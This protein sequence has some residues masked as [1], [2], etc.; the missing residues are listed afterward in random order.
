M[1]CP[2]GST[3]DYAACCEPVI[4]G[5]REAATCEELMRARYSSYVKVEMEFLQESLHPDKREDADADGAREWA[6]SSQ[7][8]GLE[9]VATADGESGDDTGQVEFIASYTFDG[10]EQHYREIAEFE[11]VDGRWYFTEG[12][13]PVR[14]PVVREEPKIG[15]NDPCSCGSGKKYKRCCGA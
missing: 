13:P 15:R 6:E 12:L 8:H 10:E 5:T 3:R 2:C 9:I 11:R 1:S 7:W 14:T 4:K